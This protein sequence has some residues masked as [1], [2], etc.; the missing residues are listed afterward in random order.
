MNI[1][2]SFKINQLIQRKNLS[3]KEQ[4]KEYDML[5]KLSEQ[6]L[7]NNFRRNPTTFKIK[8]SNYGYSIFKFCY[9]KSKLECRY[10]IYININ[11]NEAALSCDNKC[12]HKTQSKKRQSSKKLNSNF[13]NYNFEK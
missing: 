9:V 4:I 5:K 6:L 10:N 11:T 2:N 1:W 8:K 12:L 3:D 7:V 13:L